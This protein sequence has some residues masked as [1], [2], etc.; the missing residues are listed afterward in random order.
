MPARIP[1]PKDKYKKGLIIKIEHLFKLRDISPEAQEVIARCSKSTYRDRRIDPG[2]FR[3]DELI[4]IAEKLKIPVW[5]LL[6]PEGE[7]TKCI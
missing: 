7:N 3:L 2:K 6:K 1:R 4:R 5:E